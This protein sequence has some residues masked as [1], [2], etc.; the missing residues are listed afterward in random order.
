MVTDSSDYL[1]LLGNDL[2]H[3]HRGFHFK[4]MVKFGDVFCVRFLDK[5]HHITIDM[6]C[7]LH[8]CPAHG[9]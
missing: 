4:E 9:T 2:L 5:L 7:I 3:E 6:P 1:F 8:P